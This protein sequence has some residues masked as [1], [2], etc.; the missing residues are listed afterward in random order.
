MLYIMEGAY[1]LPMVLSQEY[2]LG[3]WSMRRTATRVV[4]FGAPATVRER[5]NA[6]N[7]IFSKEFPLEPVIPSV[8]INCRRF[9][10][11]ARNRPAASVPSC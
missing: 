11:S 5:I 10:G 8:A 1:S 9:S 6:S 4:E 2:E 7:Q 3:F